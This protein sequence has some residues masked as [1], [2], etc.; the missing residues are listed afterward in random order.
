MPFTVAD[1]EKAIPGAP[2]HV[3]SAWVEVAN[4]QLRKR[5][6]RG[7]PFAIRESIRVANDIAARVPTDDQVMRWNAVGVRVVMFIFIG[8]MLVMFLASVFAR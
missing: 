7:D 4:A 6:E 1:A 2:T 3:K 5:E 8:A